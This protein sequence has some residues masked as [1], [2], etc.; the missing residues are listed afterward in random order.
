MR[1]SILFLILV[2]IILGC[3]KNDSNPDPTG[4]KNP[5]W[6]IVSNQPDILPS[7][8][9]FINSDTGFVVGSVIESDGSIIQGK[10]FKTTNGGST[11][12]NPSNDTIPILGSVFFTDSITGFT[13]GYA[14]I[15]KTLDGGIHWFTVFDEPN[16]QLSSIFFPDKNTGYAVGLFGVILKTVDGGQNW[17]YLASGTICHLRSVYF[18]D[19]QTGC[20]VGYWNET[21]HSYGIIIRTTNGGETWDSIPTGQIMP[22]SVCFPIPSVGFIVSVN[23]VLK[24]RDGGISWSPLPQVNV[25]GLASITFS[26]LSNIFAVGQNGTIIKTNDVGESWTILPSGTTCGLNSAFFVNKYIGYSIGFDS[27]SKSTIILKWE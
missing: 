5:K 15:I 2:I 6:R 12:E 20:S 10:I 23:A 19:A 24:T 3:N 26:D 14:K 13:A 1:T 16:D 22:E 4:Y 7:S 9:C 18:T 8:V 21:G 27:Q 25:S 11:W 17:S